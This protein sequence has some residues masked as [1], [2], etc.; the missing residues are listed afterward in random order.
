MARATP[1]RTPRSVLEG[2]Q[3][4]LYDARGVRW[5]PRGK[6]RLA[7]KTLERVKI[8]ADKRYR[9][10]SARTYLE[11]RQEIEDTTHGGLNAKKKVTA[12]RE[13]SEAGAAGELAEHWYDRYVAV[14]QALNPKAE[15]TSKRW[16]KWAGPFFDKPIAKLTPDAVK[17]ARD[18]LARAFRAGEIS[19][20]TANDVYSNLIVTPC[21]RAWTDDP[22]D[23]KEVHVG[24]ARDN[25]A[26]GIGS[27]VSSEDKEESE[28]E[29]QALE[30][31]EF[32]ALVSNEDRALADR[33]IDA[34]QAYSGLSPS[35]FYGLAPADIRLDAERPHFLLG[36]TLNLKSGK[37]DLT[38][39][40]QRNRRVPIHPELRPLMRILLDE[41]DDGAPYMFPLRAVRD[42]DLG[43]AELREHLKG[44]GVTRDELLKGTKQLMPFDRR[45]FR[46]TF[47]TWCSVAGYDSAWLR[48]WLGHKPATTAEKHYVKNTPDFEDVV[49]KAQR[50]GVVP[51]FPPLPACL[52]VR[53]KPNAKGDLP[54]PVHFPVRTL[55]K[56]SEALISGRESC[57]VI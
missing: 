31:V 9:E 25:P 35:E 27:P 2:T 20:K 24:P 38:K 47:A 10:T 36:R 54:K 28:R 7:D 23:Y 49:L 8:P 6:I 43:V 11:S 50:P 33:Q 29:R 40:K 46:T 4:P 22:R 12:A 3:K 26:L 42:L 45:S 18:N 5:W 53:S 57:S 21:S 52:L 39:N 17:A 30:P 44:A 55:A 15:N 56:I 32:L 1:I 19:G 41:V 14:H 51:P 37:D 13:A 16:R 34:V 48:A